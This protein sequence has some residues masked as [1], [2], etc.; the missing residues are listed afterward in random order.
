[1][2]KLKS[3]KKK[4]EQTITERYYDKQELSQKDREAGHIGEWRVNGVVCSWCNTTIISHH[5]HDFKSCNC[6]E[7]EK[8]VF[9]DGGSWY[10]RRAMGL[11]AS[12]KDI[13]KKYKSTKKEKA[14]T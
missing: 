7:I 4:L 14:R 1:M 3:T 5:R 13:S 12:Y 8:Q 6:K 10:L 11:Q 9:V 2:S